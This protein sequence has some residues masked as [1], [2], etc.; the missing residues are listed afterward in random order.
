MPGVLICESL[1]QSGAILISEQTN[2][3]KQS[4]PVV[5][6]I[7]DV[8]FRKIVKP[9]DL[10]ETEVE[11]IETLNSVYFLKG[12]TT[13]SGKTVVTAK[14]ACTMIDGIGS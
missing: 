3:S 7:Q 6:R 4:I 12:R 10:L 13:V 14:F 9:G 5:T 11:I 1:L 2:F 8:K